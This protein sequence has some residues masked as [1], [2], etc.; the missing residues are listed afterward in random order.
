M[1]KKLATDLTLLAVTVAST[2]DGPDP[3]TLA[4]RRVTA[5]LDAGYDALLAQHAAY[6]RDFWGRSRVHVPDRDILAHY[7]LVRYFYG[8]A[9]R[10]GA[11]DSI[12][13]WTLDTGLWLRRGHTMVGRAHASCHRSR[14]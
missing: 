1:A 6:W 10:R 2:K 14:R 9:S 11:K 4:R 8:S 12:G 7:Y 5:A 3:V 13:C